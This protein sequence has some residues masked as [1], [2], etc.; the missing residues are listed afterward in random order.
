MDHHLYSKTCTK[1]PSLHLLIETEMIYGTVVLPNSWHVSKDLNHKKR[2]FK[3]TYILNM[4]N[5]Q[6]SDQNM[7]ES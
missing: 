6:F 7:L 5:T 2:F 1:D 4:E 3:M